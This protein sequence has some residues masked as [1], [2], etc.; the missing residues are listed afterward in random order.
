M[1]LRPFVAYPSS[2]SQKTKRTRLVFGFGITHGGRAIYGVW[3]WR[4]R[5]LVRRTPGPQGT[6]REHWR[7][8]EHRLE[9]QVGQKCLTF[10]LE[11]SH[12]PR[13]EVVQLGV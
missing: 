1:R 13:F 10:V 9:F 8:S 6:M 11:P 2:Y 4:N 5:R 7:L 3:V 12:W